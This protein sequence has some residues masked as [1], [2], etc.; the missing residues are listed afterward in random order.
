MEKYAELGQNSVDG[1]ISIERCS[2]NL[3]WIRRKVGGETV[4]IVSFVDRAP[5]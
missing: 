3:T 4:D 5:L 1:G 2:R